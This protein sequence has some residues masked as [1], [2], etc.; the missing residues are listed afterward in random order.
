MSKLIVSTEDDLK[1]NVN[2]V[3]NI[4]LQNLVYDTQLYK[5]EF[6]PIPFLWNYND[7]AQPYPV[8]GVKKI[9]A[10]KF[11]E[12]IKSLN[13]A[14][15]FNKIM[16]SQCLNDK[17]SDFYVIAQYK[18]EDFW[19]SPETLPDD[20]YVSYHTWLHINHT[21]Q[22][23]I[24]DNKLP[25]KYNKCY[26]FETGIYPVVGDTVVNKHYPFKLTKKGKKIPS[27]IA[28]NKP[29]PE[30]RH[31]SIHR[32]NGVIRFS[33]KDACNF[34]VPVDS[35]VAF[36]SLM[37]NPCFINIV[38]KNVVMSSLST[39]VGKR[40]CVTL[41]LF[42]NIGDNNPEDEEFQKLIKLAL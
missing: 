37:K 42:R 38:N 2:T 12:T 36:I 13:E 21:K 14:N 8:Y 9:N 32:A 27:G 31:A 7:Y 6:P 29:A 16:E 22:F 4:K 20:I 34:N 11:K 5:I 40:M 17:T 3:D 39:V 1:V 23:R 15:N 28:V 25:N 24:S 19:Y 30:V 35:N 41:H 10:A 26:K 18:R 33:G